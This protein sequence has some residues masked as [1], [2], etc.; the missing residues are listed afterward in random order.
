MSVTNL[1]PSGGVWDAANWQGRD[2]GKQYQLQQS[3]ELVMGQK[4]VGLF[5]AGNG[6]K[7]PS[8]N[9]VRSL[10]PMWSGRASWLDPKQPIY[11][12]EREGMHMF[13]CLSFECLPNKPVPWGLMWEKHHS[14]D[15][16]KL[17]PV[18]PTAV[19][20]KN[21][22]NSLFGRICGGELHQ[23]GSET[24]LSNE[25]IAQNFGV[26]RHNVMVEID[27]KKKGGLWRVYYC[28]PG[29]DVFVKVIEHLNIATWPWANGHTAPGDLVLYTEG[30]LYP[31]T[32]PGRSTE[33]NQVVC[34]GE[35]RLTEADAT[36]EKAAALYGADAAPGPGPVPIPAPVSARSNIQQADVFPPAVVPWTVTVDKQV[37]SVQ[38]WDED[39]PV[40]PVTKPSELVYATSL[41]LRDGADR[42]E[43]I[44]FDVTLT[45]GSK[46]PSYRFPIQRV[47]PATSPAKKLALE[48]LADLDV[49]LAQLKET[50]T[51]L[52]G[53]D[54]NHPPKPRWD[55]ALK[56]RQEAVDAIK[57]IV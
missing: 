11:D 43:M 15:L 2:K 12:G 56:A 57:E 9:T 32:D 19:Y 51:G 13:Q 26:G 23:G 54:I 14:N 41:D 1:T 24:L 50:T 30:G 28:A 37:K 42:N 31:V 10:I 5:S 39:K 3:A 34:R 49:E 48:A 20:T 44:G 6:D 7:W 16:A 40:T 25:V 29:K 53:K 4:T 36:F 22:N 27:W 35:I 45:D 55:A 52:K 47:T 18:A 17:Q 8:N 46:G 38:F 21:G 33:E